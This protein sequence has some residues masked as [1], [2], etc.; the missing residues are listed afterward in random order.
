MEIREKT[1]KAMEKLDADQLMELYEIVLSMENKGRNDSKSSYSG[2][3]AVRQAL[4][5]IEGS[6]SDEIALEREDRL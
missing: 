1:I 6:L 3:I 2:Y 5:R 4:S